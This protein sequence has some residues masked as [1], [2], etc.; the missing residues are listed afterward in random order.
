MHVILSKL[1]SLVFREGKCRTIL[2][3]DFLSAI[4]EIILVEIKP[5]IVGTRFFS[6]FLVNYY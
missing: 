4:D 6:L 3:A 1:K 2:A 5:F